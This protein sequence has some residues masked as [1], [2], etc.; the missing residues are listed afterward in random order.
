M[1]RAIIVDDEPLC[2]QSLQL[3]LEQNC[4]DVK[5]IG[6]YNNGLVALEA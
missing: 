2:C 1:I 5:V 4:P 6:I 3:L